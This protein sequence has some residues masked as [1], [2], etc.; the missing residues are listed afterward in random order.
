MLRFNVQSVLFVIV[1]LI[2]VLWT[3]I[4]HDDFIKTPLDSKVEVSSLRASVPLNIFKTNTASFDANRATAQ[5]LSPTKKSDA[6]PPEIKASAALVK[7]LN[8]GSRLFEFNTYQR[9][10]LASLSKLTPSAPNCCSL[11]AKKKQ[12]SPKLILKL[13]K[14]CGI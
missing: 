1:V 14:Y 12:P 13:Q 3:R 7:E 11:P 6:P 4:N 5:S 9:W 10:P 8:S 2:F